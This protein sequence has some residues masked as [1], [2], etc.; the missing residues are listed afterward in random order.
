MKRLV[1]LVAVA[2]FAVSVSSPVMAGHHCRCGR[3]VRYGTVGSGYYGSN[4]RVCSSAPI[5]YRMIA[6]NAQGCQLITASNQANEVFANDS[7]NDSLSAKKSP[8][9]PLSPL[10][11]DGRSP[12]RPIGR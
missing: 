2:A 5:T 11:S 4:S 1:T 10:N 12:E 8:D 7:P 6:G 9:G 3:V